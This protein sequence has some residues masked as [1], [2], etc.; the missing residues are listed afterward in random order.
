MLFLVIVVGLIVLFLARDQKQT[1]RHQENQEKFK[2]L[3]ERIEQLE[4]QLK[5]T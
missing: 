2:H 5:N 4:Q 1:D 3:E